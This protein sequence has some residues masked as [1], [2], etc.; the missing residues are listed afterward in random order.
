MKNFN[1]TSA[2]IGAL[3]FAGILS[4]SSATRVE[5]NIPDPTIEVLKSL[6]EAHLLHALALEK[7]ASKDIHT[8]NHLLS[9]S[10]SIFPSSMSM[11]LNH[12][13]TITGGGKL[14]PLY[15]NKD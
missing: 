13:L 2:L 3:V 11:S 7:M 14:S 12:D 9:V 8:V 1:P 4:L 5:P 15:I 10:G 6:T